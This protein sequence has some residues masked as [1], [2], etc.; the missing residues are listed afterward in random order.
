MTG[1]LLG[2]IAIRFLAEIFLHELEKFPFLQDAAYLSVL[3]V[4]LRLLFKIFAPEFDV[5]E[6]LI[7]GMMAGLFA[8]GFSKQALVETD[9][10][11]LSL[12]LLLNSTNNRILD[13]QNHHY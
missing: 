9:I 8:W 1:I 2:F 10:L 7:L 6:W 13:E 5:P 11:N 3:M 4:G 12:V